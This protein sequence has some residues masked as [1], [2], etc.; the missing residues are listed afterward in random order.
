LTAFARHRLAASILALVGL[1]VAYAVAAAC[2]LRFDLDRLL[3]PSVPLQSD[4]KAF[5]EA[6]RLAGHDGA[7]M[8]VRR[9]DRS[10]SSAGLGC[11]VY[12]PGHEGGLD[13]YSRDLFPDLERA[14]LVV[15][16]VAY[17]GQD[18]AP[19]RAR[20]D[21]V[22]SL[23]ATVVSMVV[24]TCGRNRTVVAG[25]S[26][27]A[28]IAAYAC[29]DTSPA[30]L[31]LESTAPSLSAGIRGTLRQHW[32]LRPL[33]LI[34]IGGIVAHDFSLAEALPSRLHVAIFQGSAD[35]RTPLEDLS[36]EAVHAS[37]VAIDGGTHTDTLERARPAMI[38]TMLGMIR[39]SQEAAAAGGEDD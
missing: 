17:P 21:D 33:A 23:A 12:F 5:T 16:A 13:R 14:G 6:F 9:F 34:P 25:R 10:E 7:A 35:T 36:N 39:G 24:A 2:L 20:V 29:G 26:L 32:F 31:V 1:A 8:V 15:Y 37:I 22:Q 3:F 27:G 19:G 18:G 38:A 4:S 11:V 28:M 30:G